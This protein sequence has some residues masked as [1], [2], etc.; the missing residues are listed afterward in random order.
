MLPAFDKIAVPTPAGTYVIALHYDLDPHVPDYTDNGGFVYLGDTRTIAAQFG[1]AAHD[2]AELLRRHSANNDTLWDYQHRSAAALSRYLHLAYGLLGVLEVHRSGDRYH[3]DTPS[4]DR[5]RGV[6]GLAW[7]PADAAN[8]ENYTRGT[9]TTYDA[10]ANGEVYG[11]IVTA[12]DGREI[13]SCWDFYEDPD[14]SVAGDGPLGLRYMITEARAQIY[15]DAA[16]RIAQANTRGAGLV[17][18]I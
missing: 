17:G 11:Y 3:A 10:W 4:A 5:H 6:D 12:P 15:D 1:D 18:L 9:V 14:E 2:V 13:Q 7:S 16:A 8:P